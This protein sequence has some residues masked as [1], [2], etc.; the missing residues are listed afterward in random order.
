[1][2]NHLAF[3]I[4]AASSRT[5]IL[6]FIAYASSVGGAIRAINTLGSASFIG[7]PYVIWETRASAS[8]IALFA[9]G[10]SSARGG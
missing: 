10:V 2:I 7:V 6:A 9:K 5:G 3:R 1:M 8:V 4:L